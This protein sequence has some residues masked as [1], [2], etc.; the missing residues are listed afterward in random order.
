MNLLSR[1]RFLE[2]GALLGLG[3]ACGPP[4]RLPHMTRDHVSPGRPDGAGIPAIPSAAWTRRIGEPL[5]RPGRATHAQR[6]IDDGYWQGLPLGGFGSGSIGRT[7]R[8]DFA[9][10]HLEP[11][12]HHY[13]PRLANQFAVRVERAGRTRS[14]VLCTE[15]P[16]DRL[17]GWGWNY[18][19][20]RGEYHALF[21]RAWFVYDPDV[22]GCELTVRQFSP[23]LPGNYRETSYPV[24]VFEAV[25]HN[26]HAEPIVV[27]VLLTWENLVGWER[28]T[29]RSKGQTNRA[30][31]EAHGRERLVGVVL[32]GGPHDGQ[33]AIGV[34]EVPGITA[35][36]RGRFVTNAD[37]TD[38]W[39]DFVDD[40]RLDDVDHQEP[41][42]P[43][44]EIGA[45]VAVRFAL[46]P[47]ESQAV[48]FALAWDLP[49]M[50]FGA[51]NAGRRWYR[52][53]TAFYG[54]TGRNAWAIARDALL[55]ATE[56]EAA[57]SAWQAP[58]LADARTP[59][60]Y[61]TALFNELYYLV[62]G[63]TA[64][65]NGEVGR[66]GT[67]R[68]RFTYLE[69]YDYP[70]Y[71]T[72]DVRFYGSWA[73]LLL[74]PELEMQELRQFAATVTCEDSTPV[75]I[76]S[77]GKSS[78]RKR[79]GALPHDLGAPADDPW[80]RPNS[81]AWQDVGIWKDL[82]AKFV[83]MVYRDYVVIGDRSLLVDCWPAV[84][85]ALAYL[86]QFDRDGDGLPENDGVP[87][88]TYDTWPM[89]GPS[90]YCGSLWL[91]ALRAA[92]AIG[93]L[94]GDRDAVALYES[95]RASAE[96]AYD[97]L[98]NDRYYNFDSSPGPHADTIM[99][100]Q[101][102]GQWYAQAAGLPD[103]VPIERVRQVLRTVYA[104]NVQGF[105]GGRMG[106]VNGIR[107]DGTVDRTSDQSQEAWTGVSYALAA[108]MLQN[109]MLDEAFA[110]AH[111]IYDVTYRT[112]GLWFRTPEAWNAR[113]EYR[114]SMYMRPQ[115]IWAIEHA[116]NRA[117]H[118]ASQ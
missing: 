72:L 49:V 64:W 27:S 97:R 21:P 104:S 70:F 41:A 50:H 2:L 15:R 100:D 83:L 116:L 13:Q 101:L 46:A 99:A 115:A 31:G 88:Q 22:V 38:L 117:E 55:H 19:A 56:W 59:E 54:T 33:F 24:G 95:W 11:G 108:F 20:G 105:A 12:R 102:C 40:G 16:H 68:G 28:G 66:P 63:G 65:E 71:S 107:P 98:W 74:W 48:P 29:W 90:A 25:A 35:S 73:L 39:Q 47:G 53:Y 109:G 69:S 23:V 93:G 6:Q 32:D 57:I 9:R 4:S 17:A 18:P 26:P 77:T 110:T 42:A 36:Y 96:R 3:L 85:E 1:R 118:G 14:T 92:E 61:K 34:R 86:K 58:I 78:V 114:A 5:S 52:R 10:W 7:Y 75:T 44:E 37:G 8:G 80:L 60:W 30:V 106:A 112:R 84:Q 45:A 111:G 103:I 87:D 79:R 113:G 43:H 94:L 51:A 89:R 62:D 81:Y 67:A 76:E 82:N 91:A